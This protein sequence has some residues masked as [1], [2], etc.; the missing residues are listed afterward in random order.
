ML[1]WTGI[2]VEASPRLVERIGGT[3]SAAVVNAAVSARDGTARFLDVTSGLTQM[4]GLLDHYPGE[5]LR[6]IRPD[7]PRRRGSGVA[8]LRGAAPP[9]VVEA[10]RR[11][12]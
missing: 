10:G 5:M 9:R 3:R 7:S 11:R 6:R 8:R 1:S 2:V 4:G 12:G